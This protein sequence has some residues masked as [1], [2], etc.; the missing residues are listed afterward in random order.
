MVN[1]PL[2]FDCQKKCVAEWNLD[3]AVRPSAMPTVQPRCLGMHSVATMSKVHVRG[4]D[5][6]NTDG[7]AG[8]LP[9]KGA[10]TGPVPRHAAPGHEP[11]TLHGSLAPLLP[12]DT[13]PLLEM[14][15]LV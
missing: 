8:H 14:V 7:T 3:T 6:C 10:S 13:Q 9:Q 1:H 11:S 5:A 4:C 12:R 15:A 2:S